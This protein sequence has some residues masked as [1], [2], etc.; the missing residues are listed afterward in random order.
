MSSDHPTHGG[1]HANS[2]T[3]G[4]LGAMFAK[5]ALPIIFVM[6]M[7]G[8][9]AVVD[10]MF[11]GHFVGA[12]ALGAVTLMF[13]LYMLIVALSTLVS[14]G[15]ASQLARFLGANNLEAARA[16]YV[17]AHGLALCISV[18]LIALFLAFGHQV[19]LIAAAGARNLADMGH[20]YL[21]ITVFMTPLMFVLSLNSDALRNEGRVGLMAAMSL[22]VSLSN[23]G[24]N[25]V[26]IALMGLGIAGSAYGT[27]LAQLLAFAIL[28]GFRVFGRTELRPSAMLRY[29]LFAR[30]ART[31]ALGAP[32]SLGFMGLALGAGAVIVALQMVDTPQYAATVSAYGIITRV[33]TFCFLPLLGLS[34]ALQSIIGNNYGAKL[35]HRSDGSLK[36]GLGIALAYC[37]LVEVLLIGFA[38]PV[39]ELFVQD[40][41]VIAEL[42]RIL[43]VM[44][45]L[46]VLAGPLMMLSTYFQAIGDA[47]RAAVL[48]LAK[49]YAFA[50]PLTFAL[51]LIFGEPGIWMVGPMAEIGLLVLSAVVLFERARRTSLRWG[52]F[53]AATEVAK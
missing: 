20:I 44:V 25:Y 4:P 22:L 29:S 31:L 42:V 39:G 19:T 38:R 46:F 3:N 21:G 43:P 10:A 36:L 12:E 53:Q 27:A 15:T 5:T 9:L 30:W 47:S 40:P 37:L 33:M 26:L 52:L 45:T 35:W 18:A 17:G 34:H 2:F 6:S 48:G 49:S 50:L 16:V 1:S 8:L 24:F 23:I 14:S 32:Q 7:S 13:P 11:L 41:V 51:P 28:M